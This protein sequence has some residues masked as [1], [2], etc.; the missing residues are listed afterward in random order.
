M[1]TNV[2]HLLDRLRSDLSDLLPAD[3]LSA[4]AHM[5]GRPSLVADDS[6]REAFS[7]WRKGVCL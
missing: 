2:Y 4:A 7:T 1:I 6:F 5:L 3:R